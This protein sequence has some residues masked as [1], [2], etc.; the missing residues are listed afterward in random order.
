MSR[1]R[2]AHGPER[3]EG[4]RLVGTTR[5]GREIGGQKILLTVG[6]AAGLLLVFPTTN[7]FNFHVY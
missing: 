4:P 3:V 7:L 5:P 1:F 6:K 2:Q